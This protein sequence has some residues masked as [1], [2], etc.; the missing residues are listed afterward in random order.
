MDL[1]ELVLLI[2]IIYY[3]IHDSHFYIILFVL[4]SLILMSFSKES[5]IFILVPMALTH[6]VFLIR[7]EPCREGFGRKKWRKRAK[8]ARKGVRKVGGNISKGVRKV[9]GNISKGV[10]KVGGNIMR[11]QKM[12][13]HYKNMVNDHVRKTIIYEEMLKNINMITNSRNY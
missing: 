1:L 8:K 12:A 10:S 7:G 13:D 5:L 3:I 11:I 6:I 2:Q 4:L 9:G